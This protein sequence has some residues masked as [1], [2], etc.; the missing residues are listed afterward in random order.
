MTRTCLLFYLHSN[1]YPKGVFLKLIDWLTSVAVMRNL[2]CRRGGGVAS[3]AP[4]LLS[5]GHH[6]LVFSSNLSGVPVGRTKAAVGVWNE[7]DFEP[8]FPTADTS[9]RNPVIINEFS[10]WDFL[11]TEVK[12]AS[13]CCAGHLGDQHSLSDWSEHEITIHVIKNNT[14]IILYELS[15]APIFI[16]YIYISYKN[17]PSDWCNYHVHSSR[18]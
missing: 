17:I 2:G 4:C 15:E 9:Y 3:R 16:I 1:D 5:A 6:C 11:S 7:T 8:D 14:T 10:C 13:I 18:V 12:F